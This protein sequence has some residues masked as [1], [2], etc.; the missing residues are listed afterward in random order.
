M[1]T[2]LNSVKSAGTKIYNTGARVCQTISN[3]G[4]SIVDIAKSYIGYNEANGSYK[5]FTDGRTEAWCVDFVSYC[6]RKC[7]VK[8]FN[9]RGVQGILDWGKRNNRF[10]RTPKVGDAIIFKGWDSKR[11]T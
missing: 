10:S 4:R 9:F 11:G 3:F 7:G 8:G 5:L 1:S 2:I 6:A